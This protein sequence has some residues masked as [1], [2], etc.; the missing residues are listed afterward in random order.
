MAVT[1]RDVVVTFGKGSHRVRALDRA[2]VTL[3]DGGGIFGLVSI[4][5]ISFLARKVIRQIFILDF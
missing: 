5:R 4:L 3:P 2:S 1:F